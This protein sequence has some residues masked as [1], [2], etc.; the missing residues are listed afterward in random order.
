MH[1]FDLK[2]ISEKYIELVNPIS[3]KKVIKVGELLG[4]NPNSRVIEFGCG[5]GEILALWAEAFGISG[6]GIELRDF[7]CER[8]RKKMIAKGLA[9][10]IEIIC[11]DG[12]KYKFEEGAFDVAACIG[13]TFIWDDFQSCI[14]A[15][16]PAVHSK[17]KLAIGET[18]WLKE[19]VPPEYAKGEKTTYAESELLRMIREEEYDLE[20]IARATHNEWDNY[21][22]MDWYGYLRWIE[23]NPNHPEREEVIRHFHMD[24]DKYLKYDR[25][26]MGWAIYVLTPIVY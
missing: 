24:Q 22:T 4:L 19:R 26:Y 14:K 23:Q 25:E 7:A 11:E 17:G 3:P 21:V 16:K 10:R 2:N 9:D 5:Y 1:F 8:A 18:Y 12:A 6:V 15:I 20:Y 13:A